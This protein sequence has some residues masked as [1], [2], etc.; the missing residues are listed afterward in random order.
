MLT[1]G[2]LRSLSIELFTPRSAQGVDDLLAAGGRLSE[3]A[4]LGPSFVSVSGPSLK[5]LE[6]LRAAHSIRPQLQ[7]S[8][9]EATVESVTS[10]LDSGLRVGVHDV[11]IVGSRAAGHSSSGGFASTSDLVRFIKE[12]YGDR[13]CVAVCGYPRGAGGE[14]SDYSADLKALAQQVSTGA[15][16]VVCMPCFD[17]GTYATFVADARALGV[18]CDLLPGVLPVGAVGSEFRR[19]CRAIAV[20]VPAWLDEQIRA[21]TTT[22]CALAPRD[23]DPQTASARASSARLQAPLHQRLSP[24]GPLTTPPLVPRCQGALHLQRRTHRASRARARVAR[25]GGAARV[26]AELDLHPEAAGHGGLPAAEAS[27]VMDGA[28]GLA[29]SFVRAPTASCARSW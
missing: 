15:E 24:S 2:M 18:R 29:G 8:R 10:L 20:E 19:V 9:P 26:H 17:A 14:L 5:I 6:H 28:G 21:C 1:G 27:R 12:R 3:F 23:L 7:I 4:A 13:M 11:L 16:L 22:E 25:R